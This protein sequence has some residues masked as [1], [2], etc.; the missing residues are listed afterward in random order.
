MKLIKLDMYG[1]TEPAYVNINDLVLLHAPLDSTK[2]TGCYIRIRGQ[3]YPTHVQQT[4]KYVINEVVRLT[5]KNY[6]T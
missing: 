4:V 2:E 5:G 3:E 1:I 6:E